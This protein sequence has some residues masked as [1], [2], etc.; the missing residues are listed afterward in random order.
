M[1]NDCAKQNKSRMQMVNKRIGCARSKR[2][3]IEQKDKK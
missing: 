2:Y 3:N 1:G